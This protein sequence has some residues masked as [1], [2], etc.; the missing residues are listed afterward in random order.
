MAVSLC[1]TLSPWLFNNGQMSMLREYV[2]LKLKLQSMND[3]KPP[4]SSYMH[5][6]GTNLTLDEVRS[7]GEFLGYVKMVD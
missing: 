5:G 1:V 2:S 7:I 4:T 3:N 6:V